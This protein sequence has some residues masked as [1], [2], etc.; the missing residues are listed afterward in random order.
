M[1]NNPISGVILA[2]GQ[3]RRMQGK[4]KGLQLLRGM[5]LW[6]HVA[7]RLSPQV[8]QVA[9]NANR[10]TEEYRQSG[11]QVI[12]DTL[13]DY[14]G[15]LAGMLAA[16]QKMK[17][18]WYLFCPCD[19]PRI[20]PDLA[21]RLWQGRQDACAVWVHDGER[22]HP[23]LA[24]L[25]CSLEKPLYDYLVK[26]ERRVMQFLRERGGHSVSFPH[27]AACFINVNTTDDLAYWQDK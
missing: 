13:P 1:R 9:I 24:L 22:D 7:Q 23:T 14:P 3:A 12:S 19:T 25:H 2:G 15:P 27:E 5:P 17:S 16:M 20:P 26:G 11:L 8:S 10:N 18:E 4:D 21:E 6:Q